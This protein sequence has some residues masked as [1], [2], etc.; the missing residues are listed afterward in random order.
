[1]HIYL[2]INKTND[3]MYVGQSILTPDERFLCHR[4]NSLSEK[5]R[6]KQAITR[7]IH[8]YEWDG[9][10]RHVLEVVTDESQLND[11]EVRWIAHYNCMSP[12]GYNLNSGG[13]SG[14]HV[15]EE[16]RKKISASSLGKTKGKFKGSRP[17]ETK[18]RMSEASMGKPKSEETRK[19][20]S[21]AALARKPMSDET[22]AKMSAAKKGKRQPQELIDK[23]VKAITG[24][25]R[26]DEV[27][28]KMSDAHIGR[29]YAPRSKEASEKAAKSNT[30]RVRS[31]ESKDK[32]AAAQRVRFA[33]EKEE[34]K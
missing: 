26:T 30:G 19:K 20:M 14:G 24:K 29:E 25:T 22:K 1:M 6:D 18:R 17:D 15:S 10:T 2:F 34:K 16:T 11:A 23:R 32:M 7:A 13:G 12:H 31:Q 33:R 28:K 21:D 4:R 5:K 27:K 8:K 3:K 9:F